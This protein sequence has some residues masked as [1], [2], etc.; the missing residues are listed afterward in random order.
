MVAIRARY[1][2][3]LVTEVPDTA[4]AHDVRAAIAADRV[5]A[6]VRARNV[7]DPAGLAD[8]FAAGGIR[9]VEFTLTIDDAIAVIAAACGAEKAIVGAGT[10]VE[11]AQAQIAVAAGA[12]FIVSPTLQPEL[13]AAADGRPVL[14]GAFSPTEA[15]AATRAGAAAVKLFPASIGGPGHVKALLSPFPEMALIPSGGVDESNAKRFLEAG[16]IAVFAGASI[17]PADLIETNQL[18]RISELAQAFVD[19]LR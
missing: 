19:A 16:A 2:P 6:V 10:V 8:A 7:P 15:L 13:V 9:C 5:I 4:D 3:T 1:G 12:R 14:M 11:L 18:D 17:A